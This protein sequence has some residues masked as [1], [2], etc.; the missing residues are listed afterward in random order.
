[1]FRAFVLSWKSTVIDENQRDRRRAVREPVGAHRNRAPDHAP[2]ARVHHRR[3]PQPVHGLGLRLRRPAR[4]A[5]GRPHVEHRLGAV[6]AHQLQPDDRARLRAAQHGDG[7]RHRR[8]LALDPLRH[9]RRADC[10]GHRADDRHDRDVGGLLPG[11]VRP[12][13]L[14]R[15]VRA[16]RG[17]PA[18]RR[19]EPGDPH[20]RRLPVRHRAAAAEARPTASACRW[21]A[22]CARRRWCRSSPTSCSTKRATS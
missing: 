17:H 12:D 5:A 16:A 11:S 18:A 13:H 4:L 14:R 19:Q 9:R 8:R 2:H 6:H 20:A 10:G 1:M 7:G 15:E 22:S 3:A 21:P